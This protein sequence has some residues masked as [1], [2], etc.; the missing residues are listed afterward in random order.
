MLRIHVGSGLD[1]R[2]GY[3]EN[4]LCLAGLC[5]C[6]MTFVRPRVLIYSF[7]VFDNRYYS[8]VFT[9]TLH[10]LMSGNEDTEF[11]IDGTSQDWGAHRLII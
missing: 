1:F 6:L 7:I 3:A 9:L 8:L 11:D 5:Y 4:K 10:V 2:R